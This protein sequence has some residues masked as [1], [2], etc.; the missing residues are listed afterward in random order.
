MESTRLSDIPELANLLQ[1]LE[2]FTPEEKMWIL[3]SRFV[4]PYKYD[5]HNPCYCLIGQIGLG[6]R[7]LVP[8]ESVL[9][10]MSSIYIVSE[11]TGLSLEVVSLFYVAVSSDKYS[12]Q[13]Y[14][15]PIL[16]HHIIEGTFEEFEPELADEVC[17]CSF[18]VNEVPNESCLVDRRKIIGLYA[19]LLDPNDS[20]EFNLCYWEYCGSLDE[21]DDGGG[22][23]EIFG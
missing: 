11:L 7:L 15:L 10:E 6:V 14:L 4:N 19:E 21:D 22:W 16:L 23:Y 12:K 18:I 1:D 9:W 20:K 3:A 17:N 5:G 8:L 2:G 13:P